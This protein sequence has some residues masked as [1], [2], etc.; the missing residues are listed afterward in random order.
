MASFLDK[1]RR[2]R[3]LPVWE[4]IKGDDQGGR[5]DDLQTDVVK[6]VQG[7]MSDMCVAEAGVSLLSAIYIHESFC[8]D[9]SFFRSSSRLFQGR[10]PFTRQEENTDRSLAAMAERYLQVNSNPTEDV[11]AKSM[12]S[13]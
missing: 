4:A 5:S 2:S 3:G 7:G 13:D 12:C 10:S 8:L 11:D 6:V 1:R 9:S